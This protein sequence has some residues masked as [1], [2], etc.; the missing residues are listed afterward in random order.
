MVY[1]QHGQVIISSF[2]I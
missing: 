2:S 1:V